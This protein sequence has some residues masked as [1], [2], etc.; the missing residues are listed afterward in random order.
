MAVSSRRLISYDWIKSLQNKVDF[1]F[2]KRYLLI[3]NTFITMTLGTSGDAL[4][5][6]YEKLCKRQI[7]WDFKRSRNV[8]LT[9]AVI[10]PACH[11]WYKMLDSRLPGRTLA[12]VAKKVLIDQVFFS[13]INISLFVGTM[14]VLEGDSLKQLYEDMKDK[15]LILLKTE[16]MVWPP[17]MALN[18]YIV[19]P[20]FRVLFDNTVSLGFDYYYSYVMF[21]K[22]KKSDNPDEEDKTNI[23][24]IE[25]I[26]INQVTPQE[27]DTSI[28]K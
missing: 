25:N 23:K 13:P 14:A 8:C 6:N 20:R 9:G 7:C 10:G 27:S 1:L 22:D 24:Q 19:P 26:D 12:K 21:S 15:G 11:F 3:T 18:F 17:A 16:W 2:S 4:Q 5:Q 28:N